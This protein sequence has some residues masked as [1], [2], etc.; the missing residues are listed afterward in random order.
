MKNPGVLMMVTIFLAGLLVS[1]AT[2]M[3]ST[4]Y[5]ERDEFMAL[6]EKIDARHETERDVREAILIN[7]QDME[8]KLD[9][10]IDEVRRL[11]DE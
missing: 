1:G 10:L 3:F 4:D 5:V 11:R 7:Q 9:V 2:I 6:K 8:G